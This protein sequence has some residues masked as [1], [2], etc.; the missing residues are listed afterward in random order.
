MQFAQLIQLRELGVPITNED[1]L[2]AATIQN[3]QKLIDNMAR[4]Q[5]QAQQMQQQQQQVEMQELKSRAE[6]SQA[7]AIA[8]RGLG[9]ERLSRIQENEALA[10]ERRA[11]AV[12]DEEVAL[13][14][15][16]KALKEIDGIDIQHIEKLAALARM[17]KEQE[18]TMHAQV[19]SSIE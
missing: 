1:L 17:L 13:L 10:E 5:Q 6:L 11:S 9:L 3:K 15:M 18:N 2:D 16:V 7:R 14:N 12:K 4:Q 19:E 8:D